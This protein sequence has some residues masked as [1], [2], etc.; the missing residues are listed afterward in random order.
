MYDNIIDLRDLASEYDELNGRLNEDCSVCNGD[1]RETRTCASCEAAGIAKA[2][3]DECKGEGS[4]KLDGPCGKCDGV[5][6]VNELDDDEYDRLV[7]LRRLE[8]E[9]GGDLD[10]QAN[11]LEP[12]MI[13]EDY[14]RT[15]AEELANDLGLIDGDADWPL[16]YLDWD[17]AADALKVDYTEVT[18]EG[19]TYYRRSC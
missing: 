6:T 5:G 8:D 17:A 10:Y 3:C 12:T 15:Y 7:A 13:H 19:E 14:F 9:L 16:T 2:H 4:I 18:L 1:G 11:M